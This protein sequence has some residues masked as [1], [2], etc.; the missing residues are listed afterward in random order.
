MQTRVLPGSQDNDS[1][2]LGN[3]ENINFTKPRAATKPETILSGGK[4]KRKIWA[5]LKSGLFG[6]KVESKQRVQKT[7]ATLAKFR[8]RR[9]GSSLPV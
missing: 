4:Q 9:W 1:N 6:W 8:S 7:S 5:K 3:L 2:T